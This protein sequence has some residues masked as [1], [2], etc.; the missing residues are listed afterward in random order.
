MK[1]KFMSGAYILAFLIILFTLMGISF[2]A[3][4]F[5]FIAN[6]PV[7]F[8]IVVNVFFIFAWIWLVFGELRTKVVSLDIGYDNFIVKGYFGFGTPKTY[9]FTDV[10]GYR[11]SIL[12]A[13]MVVYEYLYV[14]SGGKKVIKLSQFYHKNYEELKAAIIN[15]NI[16]YLGF[17][18]FSYGR[19]LKEIFI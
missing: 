4:F 7:G 1:S 18:D 3:L 12:P 19:E 10:E 14:I 2:L 17:E 8:I 6:I 11:T 15:A 9:Y 13:S 5:F 16:K